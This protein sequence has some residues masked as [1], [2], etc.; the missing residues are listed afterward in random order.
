MIGCSGSHNDSKPNDSASCART[1]T[2]ID[3]LE[4]VIFTPIFIVPSMIS[5]CLYRAKCLLQHN[6]SIGLCSGLQ[7]RIPLPA[8]ASAEGAQLNGRPFPATASAEGRQFNG[9]P[10]LRPRVLTGVRGRAVDAVHRR[11]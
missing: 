9:A 3:R 2:S 10:S 1:A 7:G 11:L 6:E 5:G 8:T 4:S